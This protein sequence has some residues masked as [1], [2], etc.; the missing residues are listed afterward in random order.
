MGGEAAAARGLRDREGLDWDHPRLQLMDLQWADVRP[1]RGLYHRLVA[2]GAVECL[3]DPADVEAAVSEPPTD[4]RAYFRGQCLA[5]F[6]DQ[7]AR[8]AG[9]RWSSTCPATRRCSACRCSSRCGA[10]ASTSGRCSTGAVTPPTSCGPSALDWQALTRIAGE[11][12][13]HQEV[14][15]PVRSSSGPHAATATSP[16]RP[17][18]HRPAAPAAQVD[19]QEVDDLLDEIDDVLESNAESFVRGFVQ[20]GGQ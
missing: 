7:V 19:T 1:E 20:K 15:C 17:R 5:R 12:P 13:R 18:R 11:S 10:R 8:P 16:T 2:A 6:G 14:R 9:T 3:L 4:T